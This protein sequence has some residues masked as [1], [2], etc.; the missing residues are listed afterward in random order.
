MVIKIASHEM[1]GTSTN[2]GLQNKGLLPERVFFSKNVGPKTRFIEGGWNSFTCKGWN[3]TSCLFRRPLIGV[4]SPFVRGP[5][6]TW[7]WKVLGFWVCST[8]LCVSYGLYEAGGT[9][10][11][12]KCKT[13]KMWLVLLREDGMKHYLM[14]G[15][16]IIHSF[17]FRPL[18]L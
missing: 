17:F 11:S 10:W 8:I 12:G 2:F 13:Y 7:V 18:L 14:L 5:S 16:F 9:R 6:C 3:S 15:S 1:D 4:I